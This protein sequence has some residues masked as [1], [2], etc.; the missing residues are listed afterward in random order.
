MTFHIVAPSSDLFQRMCFFR[1]VF[2][3]QPPL[4]SSIS[5]TRRF[6]EQPLPL[7][8]CNLNTLDLSLALDIR[9]RFLSA[10]L[11]T[12]VHCVAP[13]QPFLYHIHVH[14]W[15][16]SEL[17]VTLSKFVLSSHPFST[18]TSS[19]F[20]TQT[21]PASGWHIS[22]FQEVPLGSSILSPP[23]G[24]CR[25][26]ILIHISGHSSL[27]IRDNL[28]APYQ[29]ALRWCPRILPL[30]SETLKH[31]ALWILPC[32]PLRLW[33]CPPGGQVASCIPGGV[34]QV[35]R[36]SSDI[37]PSSSRRGL[38]FHP[39]SSDGWLQPLVLLSWHPT[40]ELSLIRSIIYPLRLWLQV[41]FIASS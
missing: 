20:L 14:R 13:F 41:F 15:E 29:E 21:R 18:I 24:I 34:S 39:S 17:L 27:G 2:F 23:V 12:W 22:F 9:G 37:G 36:S 1:L 10:A 35:R 30:P 5:W 31:R 25:G 40:L 16:K 19:N 26:G 7:F 28:G 6:Q 32:I 8:A 11:S 38:F 4:S 33:R 3:R